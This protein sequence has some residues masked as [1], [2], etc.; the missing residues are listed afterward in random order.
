LSSD[1]NG[2]AKY[3]LAENSN[4]DTQVINNYT[5]GKVLGAFILAATE[6]ERAYPPEEAGEPAGG[7]CRCLR[8]SISE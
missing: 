2:S 7:E 3:Y 4:K 6:Y 1:R 8:V 5:Q